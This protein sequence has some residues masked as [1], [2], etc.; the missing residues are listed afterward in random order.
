MAYAERNARVSRAPARRATPSASVPRGA[1]FLTAVS[2]CLLACS[3][4]VGAPRAPRQ[5]QCPDMSTCLVTASTYCH[6]HQ[7]NMTVRDGSQSGP[8][9]AEWRPSDDGQFHLL[10]ACE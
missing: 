9:V 5:T 4:S 7:F 6:H 8:T 2:V 3:S 10:I 1:Q